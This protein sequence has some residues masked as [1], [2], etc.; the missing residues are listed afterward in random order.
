MTMEQFST[1]LLVNGRYAFQ[2][3]PRSGGTA[4]VFPAIDLQG[5]DR[6]AVKIFRTGAVDEDIIKELFS[7]EVSALQ[8]LKHNSIVE[9]RDHGIDGV[10]G[11]PF[12]VLQWMDSDISELLKAH[13]PEGWDSFYESIGRPLLGAIAY[14]HSR[15]IIHRDVKPKNILLDAARTIKLADFGISKLKRIIDPGITLKSLL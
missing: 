1:P 5:G 14:A 10:S 11:K 2:G 3:S 7:R 4:D 12:V 9:M 15:Q 6:V 8:D 13:R